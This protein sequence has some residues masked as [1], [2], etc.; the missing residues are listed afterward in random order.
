[1]V[2]FGKIAKQLLDSNIQLKEQIRTAISEKKL[3]QTLEIITDKAL[4]ARETQILDK[5]SVMKI[6]YEI[7]AFAFEDVEKIDLDQ[8]LLMAKTINKNLMNVVDSLPEQTNFPAPTQ[9][10]TPSKQPPMAPQNLPRKPKIFSS[11]QTTASN[12]TPTEPGTSHPPNLATDISSSQAND[13]LD[14]QEKLRMERNRL[15]EQQQQ[16]NAIETENQEEGAELLGHTQGFDVF[17]RLDQWLRSDKDF[18]ALV[19]HFEK[20]G[21]NAMRIH[22]DLDTEGVITKIDVKFQTKAYDRYN[23]IRIT[24]IAETGTKIPYNVAIGDNGKKWAAITLD[25]EIPA[26][27]KDTI[28]QLKRINFKDQLKWDRIMTILNQ[29]KN[30]IKAIQK[31]QLKNPAPRVKEEIQVPIY[32]KNDVPSSKIILRTYISLKLSPY[33]VFIEVMDH[34]AEDLKIIGNIEGSDL[35]ASVGAQMD[36]LNKKVH[37]MSNYNFR[38]LEKDDAVSFKSCPYCGKPYPNPNAD[39]RRC[40]NCLAKL[41]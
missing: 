17:Q 14:I 2:D 24:A 18:I 9:N 39:Y 29:D 27:E 6:A 37:D 36:R 34:I 32:I 40:P 19:D 31:L 25:D 11:T 22:F 13:P 20:K 3:K 28:E 1:M 5:V 8:K 35:T 41:K 15:R 16:E 38:Y 21:Q 26:D 10:I 30:L 12:Q 4:E 23:V 33:R 7:F